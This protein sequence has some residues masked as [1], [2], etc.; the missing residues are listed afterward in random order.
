MKRTST[1]E[2]E[3]RGTIQR[4]MRSLSLSNLSHHKATGGQ[5]LT[6]VFI[7]LSYTVSLPTEDTSE[8]EEKSLGRRLSKKAKSFRRKKVSGITNQ[9]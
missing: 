6:L 9:L 7:R 2:Q 5:P 3:L 4:K 8:P 1:C